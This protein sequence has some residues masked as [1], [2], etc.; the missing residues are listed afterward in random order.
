MTES[1]ELV[2]ITQKLFPE[3]IFLT[4]FEE[5]STDI[6]NFIVCGCVTV[7]A[8]VL[9]VC[10]CVGEMHIFLLLYRLSQL[11]VINFSAGTICRK[12]TSLVNKTPLFSRGHMMD[13][14]QRMS[15]A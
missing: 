15:S 6:T 11:S 9:Y 7:H 12:C 4:L 8:C 13:P 14:S 3:I 5:M 2:L 1:E 10:V